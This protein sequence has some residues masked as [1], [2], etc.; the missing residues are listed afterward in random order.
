MFEKSTFW[1]KVILMSLQGFFPS[2]R[3]AKRR[4]NLVNLPEIATQSTVALNDDVHST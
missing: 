4:S 2:L 1:D 3:G